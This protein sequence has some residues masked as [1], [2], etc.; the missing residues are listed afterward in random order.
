MEMSL[1]YISLKKIE[2]LFF[3]PQFETDLDETS[4]FC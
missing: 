4:Q 3:L 1:S 2:V